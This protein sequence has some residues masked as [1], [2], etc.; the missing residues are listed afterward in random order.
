MSKGS[1]VLPKRPKLD[2]YPGLPPAGKL[3]SGYHLAQGGGHMTTAQPSPWPGLDTRPALNYVSL[4]I[5]HAKSYAH[6]A[7]LTMVG[8]GVSKE[9]QEAGPTGGG[10]R[11]A[12]E[13]I[14]APHG[15]WPP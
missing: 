13:V 11:T 4:S 3:G 7:S 6:P 10:R 1:V 12:V 8:T 9:K 14:C 5:F 2:G 15:V